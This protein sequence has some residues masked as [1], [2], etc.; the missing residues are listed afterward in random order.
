MRRWVV[1]RVDVSKQRKV[2]EQFGVDSIPVAILLAGDGRE[3]ERL[4]NL[5]APE[6]L[7]KR[8]K[9]LELR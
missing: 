2:A 5:V 4:P 9:A 7:T 1:R 6:E 3:L 8:L